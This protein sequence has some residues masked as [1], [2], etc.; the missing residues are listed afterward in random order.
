[1][2]Y[3]EGYIDSGQVRPERNETAP[4]QVTD[5]A[6]EFWPKV[7]EHHLK[8]LLTIYRT[9]DIATFREHLACTNNVMLGVP[10]WGPAAE[11]LV[12]TVEQMEEQA[13]MEEKHAKMEKEQKEK[14]FMEMMMTVMQQAL[15]PSQVTMNYPQFHAFNEITGNKK[16]NLRLPKNE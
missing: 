13:K 7:I 5:S 3:H 10:G 1:M 15:K 4:P 16:V 6:A 2:S 12:L 9:G 14:Q 11:K 8:R